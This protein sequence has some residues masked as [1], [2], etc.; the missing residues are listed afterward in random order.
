MLKADPAAG[1]KSRA[2]LL[3]CGGTVVAVIGSQVTQ[4]WLIDGGLAIFVLGLVGILVW[5]CRYGHLWY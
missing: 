4:R 5:A 3:I 2:V 1:E